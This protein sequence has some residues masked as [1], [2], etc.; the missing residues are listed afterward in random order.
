MPLMVGTLIV[1]GTPFLVSLLEDLV[2]G[3]V[4]MSFLFYAILSVVG[5]GVSLIGGAVAPCRLGWRAG[6]CVGE[7]VFFCVWQIAVVVWSFTAHGFEG[8]Q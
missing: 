5:L 7:L 6:I 3:F 8:I 2:A 1:V 4:Q